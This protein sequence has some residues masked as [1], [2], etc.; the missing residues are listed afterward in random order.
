MKR[1]GWIKIIHSALCKRFLCLHG[2]WSMMM[3]IW[4]WQWHLRLVWQWRRFPGFRFQDSLCL[5]LVIYYLQFVHEFVHEKRRVS[6]CWCWCYCL[7]VVF[8]SVYLLFIHW[9]RIPNIWLFTVHSVPSF[10]TYYIVCIYTL[11]SL[12]F[13]SP[14]SSLAF[15]WKVLLG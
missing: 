3:P 7:V 11:R 10:S 1:K 9:V 5:L 13:V 6:V 2:P 4:M 14:A 12:Y 15:T 8:I